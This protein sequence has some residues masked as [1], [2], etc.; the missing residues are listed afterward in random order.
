MIEVFTKQ[1]PNKELSCQ[2]DRGD[3]G[4]PFWSQCAKTDVRDAPGLSLR[5]GYPLGKSLLLSLSGHPLDQAVL[6]RFL[7]RLYTRCLAPQCE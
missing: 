5:M 2:Q 6:V 3:V 4:T 1:R 7:Q